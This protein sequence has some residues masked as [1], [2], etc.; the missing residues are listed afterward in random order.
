MNENEVCHCLGREPNDTT[1]CVPVY[2]T[3]N[4]APVVGW[5]KVELLRVVL[6]KYTDNKEKLRVVEHVHCTFTMKK[7]PRSLLLVIFIDLDNYNFVDSSL[8]AC[9]KGSRHSLSFLL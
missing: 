3:T 6:S 7:N 9:E 8:C 2:H 1:V 5:K 4:V